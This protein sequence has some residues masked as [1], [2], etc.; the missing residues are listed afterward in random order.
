[1]RSILI[2]LALLSVLHEFSEGYVMSSRGAGMIRSLQLPLVD[3]FSSSKP[4]KF[5]IAPYRDLCQDMYLQVSASSAPTSSPQTIQLSV[6]ALIM[7]NSLLIVLMRC[8]MVDK[9]G[10]K[11]LV[12][13]AV[14]ISEIF[15]LII[16]TVM[17]LFKEAGASW[18]RMYDMIWRDRKKEK[19]LFNY[20][21]YRKTCM[22]IIKNP[23]VYTHPVCLTYIMIHF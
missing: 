5:F 13:T 3:E 19:V 11:Y 20:H 12:S 8:T 18:G 7:Q 21:Y 22:T 6:L 10:G 17:I 9:M 1:M 16:S 23:H 15:K 4:K 14:L 2:V